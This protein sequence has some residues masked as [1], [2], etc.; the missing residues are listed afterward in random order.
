MDGE[1]VAVVNPA[2][3]TG[4]R[5]DGKVYGLCGIVLGYDFIP[6]YSVRM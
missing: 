4:V 6:M 1:N 2:K 5:L 3:F